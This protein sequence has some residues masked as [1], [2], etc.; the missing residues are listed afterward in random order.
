MSEV[1]GGLCRSCNRHV[2]CSASC[3]NRGAP[4]QLP[5]MM[6][7]CIFAPV[8]RI[9]HLGECALGDIDYL[10]CGHL[11]AA[12]T[13]CLTTQNLPQ[14]INYWQHQTHSSRSPASR[15][16]MHHHKTPPLP[17]QL[18]NSHAT[19]DSFN[20]IHPT[21]PKIKKKKKNLPFILIRCVSVPIL[22]YFWPSAPFHSSS[23]QWEIHILSIHMYL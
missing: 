23:S 16:S 3:N 2:Q 6:M 11:S 15:S 14:I 17:F 7:K 19:P 13:I 21:L 1:R 8:G 4:G 22:W 5:G 9:V 20:P 18:C 10:A 12:S